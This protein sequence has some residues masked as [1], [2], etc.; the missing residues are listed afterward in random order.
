MDNRGLKIYLF[1]CLNSLD[2]EVLSG[3][4]GERP[5][6]DFKMVSLPCSGKI[7][8]LYLI[9]AFETGSDGVVIV[10]CPEGQ[11]QNLEGNLRAQKRSQVVDSLLEEIEMGKG[12]MA[13]VML[14]NGG[15]EQAMNEIRDFIDRIRKLP[16]PQAANA[17]ASGENELYE[18]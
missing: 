3:C 16:L 11:C 6:N 14:R 18:S 2:M 5:G 9:K 4:C 17:H 1:Y 10:T 8:I 12:R 15:L 7:D 13:V